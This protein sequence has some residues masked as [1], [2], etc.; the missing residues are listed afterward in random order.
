M[1][2]S[3]FGV[4]RLGLAFFLRCL[5]TL[6]VESTHSKLASHSLL[7][8]GLIISSCATVHMCHLNGDYSLTHPLPIVLGRIAVSSTHLSTPQ[9]A[10]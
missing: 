8:T 1:F 3:Q 10:S 5:A 2:I 4:F 7:P 9:L 6:L